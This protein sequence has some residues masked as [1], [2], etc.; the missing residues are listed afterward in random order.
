MCK[1]P[2]HDGQECQT[3]VIPV[4]LYAPDCVKIGLDFVEALGNGYST[5]LLELHGQVKYEKFEQLT[6]VSDGAP[7][8]MTVIS[9]L[10]YSEE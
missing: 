7:Q 5:E 9:L 3:L 2:K 6:P 10:F 1:N 4:F 8:S